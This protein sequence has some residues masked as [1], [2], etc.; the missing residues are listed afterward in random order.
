MAI[1]R[2]T[3]EQLQDVARSLSLS[4][5]QAQLDEYLDYMSGSLASYDRVDAMPENL[6]EVRYPRTAGHRP[7]AAENPHNAWYVK[8]DIVG[9][10]HG[11][12]SGKTV[13]IKDNIAVAGVPMM[14]GASILEGY[15]PDC[16]ATV[17]TRILDAGGRIAG[18]SQCEY[19]CLSGGSHTGS[20]GPVAN[21]RKTGHSAGG[22]SSGSAV[23]L[24]SGQVDLA[25]GGDQGGSIRTP[26]AW[27]GVVGLKPT[28]GLVPYSGAMPIEL[29]L[30]H[31]GPMSRSVAENA[32]LL[33]VLAGPDGLDPRQIHQHAGEDYTTALSKGVSGLRIGLLK[34]GF[35]QQG[36]ESDVEDSV[37]KAATVFAA[38]GA[39]VSEIS[40]PMHRDGPAIWSVIA[41]EG[42]TRQ[43]M[44]DN[45]H[46]F[47]WKGLYLTS[48]IDA[49]SEWHD[50]AD[51]LPDTVKYSMLLGAFMIRTGRGRHYA[52]A[53]NLAR[54][55]TDA[56]D[57]AFKS[58]DVLLMPTTPMK[59]PKLPAQ[60]AGA[61]EIWDRAWE[62][63]DNTFPFDLTGHPCLQVPCGT[64]DELPIGM[65]LVGRCFEEKT[66]YQ[67]GHAFERAFNWQTNRNN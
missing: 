59:A 26:A 28:W 36:A 4:L 9:A 47:N 39:E 16:D 8:T 38:L 18:K 55:L 51:E 57:T 53:Q 49:H 7:T 62:N 25:L 46:G 5:S 67:A 11:K 65:M 64:S 23:L 30:D 2:P 58:V 13:A 12:L 21:P 22:S 48:M 60:D 3:L 43:M 1:V 27:C 17:V 34:E 31:L 29:T 32:L 35:G 44:L 20:Q 63:M 40:V 66:L 37:N 54:K 52:K 19:Y 15:T 45:G 50:R 42:A 56:Y 41:T 33:E 14:N 24:A 6:P 10:S 61:T